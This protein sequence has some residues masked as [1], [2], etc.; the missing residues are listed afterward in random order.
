MYLNQM[1]GQGG[2]VVSWVVWLVFFM[3]FFMFYP[4]LMLFQIM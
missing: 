4:R 2:D 3:V 1:I